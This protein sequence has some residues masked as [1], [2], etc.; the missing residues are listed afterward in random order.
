LAENRGTHKTKKTR[1]ENNSVQHH[2]KP[3]PNNATALKENLLTGKA[4]LENNR[5]QHNTDWFQAMQLLH[6][7]IK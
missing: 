5:V 7:R 4:R 6:R 3:V 1:L 2:T